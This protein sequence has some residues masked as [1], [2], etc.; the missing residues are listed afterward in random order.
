M[1]SLKVLISMIIRQGEKKRS[2]KN[3]REQDQLCSFH[4]G[5]RLADHLC[6]HVNFR[7]HF[8]SFYSCEECHCNSNE[9]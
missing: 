2:E 7:T 9:Y 6:L 5:S 8:I 1:V 4:L 3:L